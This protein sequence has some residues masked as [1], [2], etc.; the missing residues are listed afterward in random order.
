MNQCVWAHVAAEGAG[1]VA[2]VGA[3]AVAVDVAGAGAGAVAVDVG[4]AGADEAVV[5]DAGPST[6]AGAAGEGAC[7][8]V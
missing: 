8:P 2:D 7:T 3:S 6:G 1:A 5:A 4:V